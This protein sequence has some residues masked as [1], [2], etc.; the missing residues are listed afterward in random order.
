MPGAWELD[1]SPI[2][3]IGI[4]HCTDVTVDWALGLRQLQLPRHTISMTRGQPI[5]LSRD[6][7]VHRMQESGAEY[8][9]FLDSD[10]ILP[11]DAV[12]RLL[13]HN[14]DIISG[15]YHVRHNPITPAMW[16]ESP[17]FPGK[18][19][20][21]VGY[22]E[23]SLIDVDSIGMGCCLIHK[24]VFEKLEEPYFKWSMDSNQENGVS[25][26]FYFCKK[27]REAGFH[28]YVDTSIQCTHIAKANVTK[29]GLVFG[30][31]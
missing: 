31:V 27:A 4:P 5:D 8:M 11:N 20:P 24:R 6:T 1:T 26:D 16:K 25:E 17:E 15:V 14:Q 29:A 28:I 7:L 9:F 19:N 23:G 22:N 10:V 30:D 3:H 12:V 13:S 2:V 18:Y 21:I